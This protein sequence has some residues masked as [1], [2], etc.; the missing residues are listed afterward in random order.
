LLKVNPPLRTAAEQAGLLK[1]LLAGRID[2][3]ETDHAPHTLTDKYEHYASGLPGFPIYPHLV[4]WLREQ[5]CTPARLAAI[6]HTNINRTFGLAIPDTQRPG[7][8]ELA[9]AYPYDPYQDWYEKKA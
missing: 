2:W 7:D 9:R 4:V 1:L 6:T 5:G 3:L 8:K